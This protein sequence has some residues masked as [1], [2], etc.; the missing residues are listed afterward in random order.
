MKRQAN[1][2]WKG[3]GKD[4]SGSLTAPSHV[5]NKTPYSFKARFENED[6]KAG[7]NPEELIAAAHA[8]CFA[9]A[10]SFQIQ[11][12]GFE[13]EELNVDATI[14][15]QQQ[16]GGFAFTQITLDLE[17]SV[18]NMNES[19]FKELAEKAKAGCP[20]SK[21]LKAVPIDLNMRFNS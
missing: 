9:M 16:D 10:L 7:T 20:V 3:T 5:L 1:A 14:T 8:G 12:A 11:E 17:G 2:I 19:Q 21:A 15:M 13:A 6:G 4:G 18:P